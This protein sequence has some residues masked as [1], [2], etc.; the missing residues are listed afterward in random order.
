MIILILDLIFPL[1]LFLENKNK[2]KYMS[3]TNTE[4]VDVISVDLSGNAVL[5]ISDDFVWDDDK[6]LF[7]LQN[8][9]N[10]YLRFIESGNLYESYP[11]AEGRNI[12]I[13]IVAKYEPNESGRLFLSS[14][15]NI[16]ESSGYG[17]KFSVL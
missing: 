5:T 7:S 9:I 3:L 15:K 17:F 10:S 6:H 14:A 1:F 13:N 11:N 4:V 12:I 16:L 8:K 2:E